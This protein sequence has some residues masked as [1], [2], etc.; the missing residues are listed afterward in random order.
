MG[1]E[2]N[3]DLQTKTHR[4]IAV[5]LAVASA[6]TESPS[7]IDRMSNALSPEPAVRAVSD[8]L[9]ILQSDQMSGTPSLM[10]ERTEKGRY[11]VVG[12]KRIFGWLPTGEDVR[13]FIEDV[14]QNVSLARKIGTFASALLVES[15]LRHG[16]Q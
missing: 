9:R 15:M 1:V 5:L 6:L 14:Q 13:R 16:E 10:T 11:V 4:E 2:T 12:N 3:S 8:A 7:L